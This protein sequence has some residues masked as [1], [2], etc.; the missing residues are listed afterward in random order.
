[1]VL[2]PRDISGRSTGSQNPGQFDEHEERAFAGIGYDALLSST[3]GWGGSVKPEPDTDRPNPDSTTPFEF[4]NDEHYAAF[5]D[6]CDQEE[7][8]HTEMQGAVML[9]GPGASLV[10][11]RGTFV[12]TGTPGVRENGSGRVGAPEGVWRPSMTEEDR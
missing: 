6:A 1:M 5:A 10:E 3:A 12:R 9:R 4:D 11:L 2:A 8:L 7:S